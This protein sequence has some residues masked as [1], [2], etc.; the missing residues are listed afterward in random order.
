MDRSREDRWLTRTL[1]LTWPSV[2]ALLRVHAAERQSFGRRIVEGGSL[3]RIWTIQPATTWAAWLPVCTAVDHAFALKLTTAGFGGGLE[4]IVA[5]PV[6]SFD[7]SCAADPASWGDER[8]WTDLGCSSEMR[9]RGLA[10][11]KLSPEHRWHVCGASRS[12][13]MRR[14]AT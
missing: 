4:R 12:L 6:P 13:A 7:S 10:S 5:T 1:Q 14:Q 8:E 11:R 2:A 9:S 3:L